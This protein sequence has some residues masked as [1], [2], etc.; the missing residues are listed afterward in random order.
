MCYLFVLGRSRWRGRDSG[1]AGDHGGRGGASKWDDRGGRGKDDGRRGGFGASSSGSGYGGSGY[2]S[3]GGLGSR[4]SSS[5]S[6]P[7]SRSGSSA[8]SSATSASGGV[9][10]LL[11]MNLPGASKGGSDR[12]A[13]Q[14]SGPAART[15]S[16][17]HTNSREQGSEGFPGANRGA[18][19]TRISSKP[20]SLMNQTIPS[21]STSTPKTQQPQGQW[22]Q[23]ASRWGAQQGSWGTPP[24]TVP[25]APTG[26]APPPPPPQT[27]VGQAAPQ[28]QTAGDKQE[29][30][31]AT[32]QSQSSTASQP[33]V[34]AVPAVPA[35]T[36][37]QLQMQA[38]YYSQWMQQQAYAG[39]AN[40]PPP[41]PN[42]PP[43]PPP[44]AWQ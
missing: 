25:A 24:A 36:S 28:T 12:K 13:G 32:A 38:F 42:Q 9:P 37:E 26:V 3:S 39:A 5:S 16:H 41:P 20:P 44:P 8:T 27:Q 31:A 6:L 18:G 10:S 7:A 4:S 21:P 35:M 11:T 15:R 14:S 2:K 19:S 1:R 23:S 17:D 30:K 43:P 29:G 34:A 33:A 22:G 40:P